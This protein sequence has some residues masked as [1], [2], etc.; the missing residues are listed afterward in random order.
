[1]E[2][3]VRRVVLILAVATMTYGSS[4]DGL[5][6]LSI[7]R[8]QWESR[9]L[10]QASSAWRLAELA[11][12]RSVDVSELNGATIHGFCIDRLGICDAYSPSDRDLLYS[13]TF[14]PNSLSEE[15]LRQF[16]ARS[17]ARSL[18]R[19]SLTRP[20]RRATSSPPERHFDATA[21]PRL[22]DPTDQ[23]FVETRTIV[24]NVTL[25]SSAPESAVDVKS[26]RRAALR[27]ATE[28][29]RACGRGSIVIPNALADDPWTLV[30][31]DLGEGCERGIA[32]LRRLKR[33]EWTMD[34]FDLIGAD[35]LGLREMILANV[36]S[37]IP[38]KPLLP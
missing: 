7:H 2:K 26:L 14:T 11:S 38:L 3:H 13:M 8:W 33:N 25:T 16:A 35:N 18:Q 37:R 15:V 6:A 17:A 34:G 10:G 12:L 21:P 1:M 27:L 9:W 22:P 28:R 20:P 19:Q 24:W 32:F 23:D 5:I 31:M 36:Q 4:L 30:Y 29:R